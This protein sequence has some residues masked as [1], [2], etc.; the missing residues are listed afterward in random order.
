MVERPAAPQPEVYGRTLKWMVRTSLRIAGW[1]SE[2]TRPNCPRSVVIAAP[3]TSNWDLPLLFAMAV[4]FDIKISW[5]AK[6]VLF[7]FPIGILFRRL[8]GIPIV[9][10]QRGNM[11]DQMVQRF[12]ESETLALVVPVEGT[13]GY[14]AHWK[15]GFYRIAEAAQVPIVMSYLDYA[16]RRG[17]FGPAVLPSG[18]ITSDMNEIRDFYA[19]KSGKYPDKFGEIRLKEEM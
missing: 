11:V 9:R 5:M 6:H 4:T 7:Q 10:H 19:D 3:H 12:G 13:R 2:G 18:D 17:G 14:V 16:R 1:E 8:G 15:S